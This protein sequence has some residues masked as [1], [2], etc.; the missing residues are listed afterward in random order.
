MLEMKLRRAAT[1][2]LES[3]IR[4]APPHARD[5]GLAMMGELSHVEGTWA[6]TVWA[7]G[8]SS[9]LARHAL[10]SLIVPDRRDGGLVPDGGLFAKSVPLRQAAL[11]TGGV[12]VLAAFLFFAASPF[13][14]AFGV[15][16]EP[17][18]YVYQMASH[19]QQPGLE[20][21][22]KQA[23]IRHDPEG[24]AFCAASL[25][26]PGENTRM[27][28]EA[29]RLDPNL[30][31]VYAVIALRQPGFP[32]NSPWLDK[33]ERW[34][35]QNALFYLIKAESIAYVSFYRRRPSPLTQEQE[36]AW[37]RAMAAAFHSPKYDD[38]LDRVAQLNRLVVPRYGFYDPFEVVGRDRTDMPAHALENSERFA[39]LLLHSGAALEAKGD[40]KGGREQYWT[41]AR[42]GQLI[43]SQGRTDREH[44]M[45]TTL[46]AM[47]YR[48][49]QA[50][51]EKEGNQPEAGI[52]G[53]LAAKADLVKGE[54]PIFPK[55]SAFGR[56]SSERNAAVVKIS[57]LMILIFSG[58][59][60]MTTSIL[61]LGSRRTA[62]PAVQRAKPLATFV[63]LTSAVGLLFSSITL[64]L[65]YRP[66]WFIF[67]AAIQSGE[68]VP[69][70][71]LH[72]FLGATWNLPGVPLHT[73]LSLDPLICSCL[74][75]YRFYVW[76]G[77]A[78]LGLVS[79][80]IILLRQI[81]P[82][83]WVDV[84]L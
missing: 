58:L 37:Q 9:V 77:A 31:W 61:I 76:A 79:L 60:A 42:F 24:L 82:R 23:E 69:T 12:C 53:Y 54:R 50:S 78:L 1:V 59:V 25:M 39:Q 32:E 20:D 64:Y 81:Q 73:Y 41:V 15:A 34:D 43:D 5:W 52:F 6:P 49:L 65:T 27:A 44:W 74:L 18:S 29:V 57:G 66:Y 84:A 68:R 13:R 40:R 14:Q 30:I 47:A 63:V 28:E 46:Q 71:D 51:A 83:P 72:E 10:V 22:A 19:N 2:L 26:K 38:Y 75:S 55:Q 70:R 21:L 17:L 16:M 45:G 36:Q 3:A 80:G 4:I 33:L 7:I 67:Q 11:V 56:D 48:Q 8:S 62:W 35:S